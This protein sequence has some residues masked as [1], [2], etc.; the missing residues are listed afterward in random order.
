MAI[1]DE[2][3]EKLIRDA[4]PALHE[5]ENVVDITTGVAQG[6]KASIVVTDKRVV[7]FSKRLGGFDVQDFAYGLL[8][9][10]DYKKGLALA[11]INLRAS[12]DSADISQV[13]KHDVER[14]AEAIRHLMVAAHPSGSVGA[15]VPAASFDFETE[16]RKLASLR[17]EGLL[18]EEE[19][20]SR[21]ARLLES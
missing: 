20:A 19:F 16:I 7:I 14:I 11:H 10:V 18:T 17:D 1:T 2:K 8:T 3:R 6:R 12:G 4:T 21:K 5:G 13:Q 15:A 9:G